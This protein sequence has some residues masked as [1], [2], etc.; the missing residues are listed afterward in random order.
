LAYS[1][2]AMFFAMISCSLLGV[3]VAWQKIS[4]FSDSLSHAVL[5]GIVLSLIFDV[6]QVLALV[7]FAVAFAAL[8]FMIAQNRDSTIMISS[9][10]C[11]ALALIL[12][13]LFLQN[14]DLESY[15]LGDIKNAGALDVLVLLGVSLVSIGYVMLG[16]KKILLLNLSEDLAR[17]S[18]VNAR[19]WHLSF[20][21]LLAVVVALTVRV[22]GIFLT[23]ALLVFPPAIARIF[24]KSAPQMIWFSSLIGMAGSFFSFVLANSLNL[25]VAPLLIIIFGLVFFTVRVVQS[26]R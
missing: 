11:I 15:I 3:F 6:N 7:I 23:T 26:L 4:Y 2:C 25:S 24:S 16:Y 21:I 22:A 1:F 10:F 19:L 13:N 14:I 5:L 12:N 20:L 18:G 9:Y 8:I 17:I